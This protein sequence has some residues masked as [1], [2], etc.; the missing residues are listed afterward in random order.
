MVRFALLLAAAAAFPPARVEVVTETLHGVTVADP[1]RWLEDQKSPATRA[2]LDAQIQYTRSVLGRVPRERLKRRLT[3][4]RRIDSIGAPTLRG[5]RYFFTRRLK[6]EN[7][8]SICVRTGFDG[9]D[10]VI[11]NPND[12]SPDETVSVQMQGVSEDATLLAYGVRKGG[13]DEIEIRLLDLKTRKLVPGTL[14]RARYTSFSLKK[15]NSGF[16]YGRLEPEGPRIYYHALGASFGGDEKIF[17]DGY[18]RSNW[19][20]ARL[21][22]EDGRWLLFN[23][24]FGAA[25]KNDVFLRDEKAQGPVRPVAVGLDAEFKPFLAGGKLFLL[26]N[27]K[28]PNYRVFAADPERPEPAHWKEIVPEGA[29]PI[30][31]IGAAGGRLFVHYLENVL[32]RIK[33]FDP[34]GKLLGEF[35]APGPGSVAGP[36]GRWSRDEAFFVYSSYLEPGATYRYHVSSGKREVWFRPVIPV[37]PEDYEEKQ[38]WF[39]SKDGTRVPMFLVHRKGLQ[40]D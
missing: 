23:V 33:Q 22:D 21:P 36:F 12:V 34:S 8:N 37:K 26:T 11:V 30:E 31:D 29:S 3:E 20:S 13:E 6:H 39:N 32:P 25:G 28:A 5:N 17:G 18:T 27:W 19:V 9:P 14:P 1:Y 24:G 10:E 35:R 7:R 2:W 4:L 16:Y 40:L 38:V 15:D